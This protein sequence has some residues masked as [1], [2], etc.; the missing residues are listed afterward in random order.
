MIDENHEC[1][2]SKSMN[3]PFPRKC[4]DCGKPEEI[5]R[6]STNFMQVI[7]DS[8]FYTTLEQIIMNVENDSLFDREQLLIGLKNTLKGGYELRDNKLLNRE[9]IEKRIV[10]LSKNLVEYY[11]GIKQSVNDN[12]AYKI[13]DYLSNIRETKGKIFALKL[14]LNKNNNEQG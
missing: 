11:E 5:E 7:P 13:D 4:V 8:H 2:Y 1:R 6:T 3:Q 12:E 9:E 14:V 10:W